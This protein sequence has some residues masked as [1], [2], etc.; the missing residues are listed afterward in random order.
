MYNCSMTLHFG[1]AKM[2]YI[3]LLTFVADKE[4]VCRKNKSENS[5]LQ[6]G[7][8]LLLVRPEP[9]HREVLLGLPVLVRLL[10]SKTKISRNFYLKA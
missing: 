10:L 9:Y 4:Y 3:L 8:E 6:A 2:Q 5:C 1:I 7:F